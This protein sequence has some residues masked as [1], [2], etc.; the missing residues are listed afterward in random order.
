V[1]FAK[2]DLVVMSVGRTHNGNEL[3]VVIRASPLVQLYLA[4]VVKTRT[5]ELPPREKA[6]FLCQKASKLK[7]SIG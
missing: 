4:G 3:L 5:Y 6:V 1:G 7:A 2:M